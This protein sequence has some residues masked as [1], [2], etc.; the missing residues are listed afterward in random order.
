MRAPLSVVVVLAVVCGACGSSGGGG[1][2][3][4]DLYGEWRTDQGSILSFLEDGSFNT[5]Y[6]PWG[7]EPFGWGTYTFD[8]E[9]L[10]MVTTGGDRGCPEGQTGIYEATF[11][12]D[13]RLS[14]SVVEEECGSRREIAASPM[15]RQ[16]P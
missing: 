12:A 7:P 8:G 13:D 14:V 15:I 2:P 16:S 10:T 11:V 4:A 1:D 5:V 9:T 6:P 3:A